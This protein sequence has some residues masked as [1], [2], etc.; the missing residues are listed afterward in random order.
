MQNTKSNELLFAP[1]W[2][3][4]AAFL[5]DVAVFIP[6]IGYIRLDATVTANP[7]GTLVIL[8]TFIALATCFYFAA[9]ESSGSQATVG[10]MIL[11]LKVTDNAGQGIGFMT[12]LL[13]FVCA[14]MTL[15]LGLVLAGVSTRKQALHD[16]WLKTVVTEK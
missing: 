7:T 3:R 12:A 11:N 4:L 6:L 9:M 5:I 1:I 10:K 14:L 2:K 13:R 15:G 8:W 16:V